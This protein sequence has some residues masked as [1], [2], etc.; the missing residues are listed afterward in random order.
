MALWELA[1]T[2][3]VILLRRHLKVSMFVIKV[4][5]FTLV[6]VFFTFVEVCKSVVHRRTIV[7]ISVSD[8]KT[9]LNHVF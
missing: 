9:G 2:L 6:K 5:Y 3:L 8:S 7:R 4:F 1:S